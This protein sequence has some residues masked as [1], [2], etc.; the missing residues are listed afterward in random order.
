MESTRFTDLDS[1]KS[2]TITKNQEVC[3][4]RRASNPL[5]WAISCSDAASVLTRRDSPLQK[6]ILC[7]EQEL[8]KTREKVCKT[9]HL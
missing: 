4:N 8:K 9:G 6:N 2:P 3:F 7:C 1:K 5:V